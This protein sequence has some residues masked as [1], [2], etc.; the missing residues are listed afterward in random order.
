MNKPEK[1]FKSSAQHKF[2]HV[3]QLS[4]SDW[5]IYSWIINEFENYSQNFLYQTL[6]A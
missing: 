6:D 5:M 3:V 1:Q 4:A 2:A